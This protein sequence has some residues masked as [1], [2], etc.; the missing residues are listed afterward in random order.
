MA[1]VKFVYAHGGDLESAKIGTKK[2]MD[3]FVRSK[4]QLIKSSSTAPDGL[5]G[6]FKGKG[7]AGKW[8]VDVTKVGITISLSFILN[9]LKGKV[10]SELDKRL[11]RQFPDGHKV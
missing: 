9:A 1:D 10:T 5:S 3:D 2:L 8:F 7:F 11:S 4:A 6:E